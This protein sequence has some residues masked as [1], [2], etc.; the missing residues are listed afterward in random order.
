MLSGSFGR[1]SGAVSLP[2]PKPRP[3]VK[4]RDQAKGHKPVSMLGPNSVCVSTD[5]SLH[6]NICI[7]AYSQS[8]V[9][10][11]GAKLPESA[12]RN[13]FTSCSA[14]RSW[15]ITRNC[16]LPHRQSACFLPSL[17]RRRTSA[18]DLEEELGMVKDCG[19]QW[20][21]IGA[22][23]EESNTRHRLTT[24]FR[25][26][27]R[28]RARAHRQRSLAQQGSSSPQFSPDCIV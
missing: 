19:R 18:D 25:V 21:T 23:P 24:I 2:Y 13:E 20:T 6:R 16:P 9:S 28:L 5:P 10:R 27:A 26:S 22:H 4:C 14:L 7:G 11:T 15:R 3:D 1:R 17:S 8:P 12:M